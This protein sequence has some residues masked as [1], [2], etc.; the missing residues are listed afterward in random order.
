MLCPICAEFQMTE[1]VGDNEV[2]YKNRPYKLVLEF[3]FCP[4]CGEQGN[5]DQ[6]KRNKQR[7]D[8]LKERVDREES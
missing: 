2:Y 4:L 5:P 3:S 7:M 8:K 6:L 1:S